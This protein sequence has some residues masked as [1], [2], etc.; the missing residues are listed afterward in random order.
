MITQGKKIEI[1]KVKKS[2]FINAYLFKS[3]NDNN[4]DIKLQTFNNPE[5]QEKKISF[6]K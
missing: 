3:F 4:Y 5:N 2:D 1:L 6:K